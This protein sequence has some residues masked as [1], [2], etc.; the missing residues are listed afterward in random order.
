MAKSFLNSLT[1]TAD[2]DLLII[3]VRSSNYETK[4]LMKITVN[5]GGSPNLK[6]ICLANF[7]LRLYRRQVIELNKISIIYVNV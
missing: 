1:K 4:L 6:I 7:S 2:V 3:C 5:S